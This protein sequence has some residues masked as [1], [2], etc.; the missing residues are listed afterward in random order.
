LWRQCG[1]KKTLPP[2]PHY[3]MMIYENGI[4]FVYQTKKKCANGCEK[5]GVNVLKAEK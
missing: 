3:T 5:S 1:D 2:Q 4:S